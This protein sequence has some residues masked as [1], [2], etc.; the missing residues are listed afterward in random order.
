MSFRSWSVLR[1]FLGIAIAL[2]ASSLFAAP[3]QRYTG[4]DWALLDAKAV[5]A[6][7]AEI[8][9][10]AYPDSDDA[11]VDQKSLRVYAADGTAESQDETFTKVLTE[12]GKRSDNLLSL[13]FTLPYSTVEVTR[14]E[15]FKPTGEAVPVDV[16]ANAKESIDDS[17]MEANI[18]DP[19]SRV[20]RVNIPQLEIGDVVHSVTRRTTERPVMAGE[21]AETSF[22]EGNGFIRHVSYEVRAPSAKRLRHV[23]LKGEVPG[24]VTASTHTDAGGTLVYHWEVNRVPRMYD[25]PAMPAYQEVLQRLL[26][27]TT[28]DWPAVSSWY[29]KLNQPHLE[30]V[31][32]E[33]KTAV[34][35]LTAPAATDQ[36]KIK[37]LFYYVAK[38]IRYM[39]IT[40]EKD[41]PGFEP[42][43]VSLTFQKKY[44]VCRDKA[45][46]LV[47][48]LR[49]AGFKAY[50][51]LTN[52]GAK[53][54]PESPGVDFNHAIA[55]VEL[56]PGS[57]VLMDP[58]DEN[59]QELLPANEGNQSYLVCRPEGEEL[60]LS[61]VDP[62]ERNMLRV[63]TTGTLDAS[64]A[65][66]AHSEV[67]FEGINDNQTRSALVLMKPDDIWRDTEAGLK[68]AISGAALQSLKITPED[69]H[70]TSSAVH[71][72][73]EFTVEHATIRG[74]GQAVATVPWVGSSWGV[75][76]ALLG[77]TGLEKR[78]YPMKTGIACGLQ[79][80]ISLKL[81]DDFAGA[82][83]LPTC[84]P[85]ENPGMSYRRQF[86]VRDGSLV[87]SRELKLKLVEFSPEQYLELKRAL[88]GT[89]YEVR[90]MPILA[91][92][93]QASQSAKK[94]SPAGA[95]V[96]TPP[97]ESDIKLLELHEEITVEDAHTQTHRYH[98]VQQILTENG[99]K[100]G[101]ELKINYSPACEQARIVHA[102]VRSKTG[103]AQEL[104]A[105]EVHVMD[106]DWNA[107]AKRYTGDKV[108]VANLPGVEIGSVTDVEYE[109]KFSGKPFLVSF[110][111]FQ[112]QNE[113]NK[114]TVRL[115]APVGLKIQTLD[116]GPAGIFRTEAMT[117]GN[118]QEWLYTAESVKALPDEGGTPPEWFYKAG[119]LLFAGDA[120][121]YFRELHDTLLDRSRQSTHAQE[122]A[123][124]LTAQTT[125][126][127]EAIRVIRDH[128]AKAIRVAG[129][130]FG[131]LPLNE[132]SAADTTLADGYGH[133]ADR[134]ILL[135]AMLAA[136]GLKP[137][138]VLASNLPAGSAVAAVAEA[139]PIPSA[140]AMPLVKVE[141]NGE[142]YYVKIDQ[143]ARLGTT[144]YDGKLA[145][146]LTDRTYE[147]VKAAKDCQTRQSTDVAVSLTDTGT[148]QITISNRYYGTDYAEKNQYFSE[149]TPEDRNHYFQEIVANLAQGARPVG[150]LVTDFKTYPGKE[151]FTVE[152]ERFAVLDGNYLY[153]DLPVKHGLVQ[154]GA[155]RRTLPLYEANKSETTIRTVIELPPGYRHLVIAPPSATYTAPDRFGRVQIS[156][157][158]GEGKFTITQ[159][160]ASSPAIVAP[161]N[162]PALQELESTLEN[163][164]GWFLLLE[165]DGK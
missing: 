156:T 121:D 158:E 45:A 103:L 149:V 74:H 146:R 20:L 54:D 107:A 65:L 95:S 110:V 117:T 25:E 164:A 14:L 84:T 89:E 96:T 70:D 93:D 125:S 150:D 6:A 15:V 32:A 21:Y 67:W 97:V 86:A 160:F 92:A 143:Y 101:A 23:V 98:C 24:T 120:N 17:Q 134:A 53:I 40:P 135:H 82:L 94:P 33:M 76:N 5:M 130:Y 28:S 57:Y 80:D 18:Y 16:A 127:L 129:P 124:Q 136:I 75:V 38:N 148:A 49:T 63:Q 87:C 46:L 88:Q 39:G 105:D 139:C 133:D 155:N 58:T 51:V 52:V 122:R 106:A 55:A 115:T 35:E 163:K 119:I 8:T 68:R 37:A 43:D 144:L 29:W 157:T 111:P 1:P 72:V 138:F 100:E 118:K 19:N 151:Q 60:K 22:F 161:E 48:L 126:Q 50:P 140:F 41:R 71:A 104:S 3:A 159:F 73:M 64:G 62:A 165:R 99:K 69:M 128:V 141:A 132:L 36:D 12:A 11:T 27:S 2:V 61:P 153:F 56:K 91:V 59:T 154:A 66:T 7:A 83:S 4:S 26:I 79:E 102:V 116:R 109:V 114:K 152:L 31:T 42:H 113:L 44:G 81:A 145:L 90:K 9:A 137:E 77:A 142:T 162:F 34:R 131:G 47:A 147:T 30:A 108:L 13:D 10:A 112:F 85:V 78:R 123:R